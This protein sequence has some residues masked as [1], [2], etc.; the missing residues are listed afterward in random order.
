MASFVMLLGRFGLAAIFLLAGVNKFIDWN[1]TLAYMQAA[2]LASVLGLQLGQMLP[3]LLVAAALLEI[4]G[5]LALIFGSRTRLAAA[6]LALFLIPT[7]LVFH[8]FW[9]VPADQ[10]QLQMIMF[11]KNLA[12]FGGLLVL[13]GAGPGGMS[14]DAKRLRRHEAVVEEEPS[15]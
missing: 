10:Y 5:A 4:L 13:M 7:T 8:N 3:V 11:F 15:S 1:A 6:L 14:A 12:I 9:A 2:G